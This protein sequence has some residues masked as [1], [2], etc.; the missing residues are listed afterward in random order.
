M[1]VVKEMC[2]RVGT[3]TG[4]GLSAVIKQ[5]YPKWVLWSSILLLIGANVINIYADLN[6]M[7]ACAQML[8]HGSFVIWLTLLTAA[9]TTLQ[10]VVPYRRYV[11]VLKW[12][13]LG[14]LAYVVTAFI[15]GVHN[16]WRAIA[17]HT[18]V[19]S[20]NQSPQ[21]FLIV[22]GFL[23]T[24][25]SPYLFFWQAGEEVEEQIEAGESDRPG[26]RLVPATD[27]ELRSLRID[28][29]AGM[30]ASQ[31]VTF[32]IIVCTATNLHEKGITD[33]NTAQDAARALLPLGAAAYWLF[34]LGILGTGALAIPTLAG[35]IAYS[36]CEA[37]DWRYGLYRRF[38][39]ARGF[40]LIIFASI[41]A[42]Y[43]LNFVRSISPIKGLLYSA[44]LNGIVAPPLIVLL[45]LACN[46]R[47]IF[48]ERVN[49]PISNVL[50]WMTAVLMGV[51]SAMLFWAM[52]TGKA[53]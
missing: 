52:A 34:A 24:T 9:I 49:K 22:I 42:G 10:I 20:W 37:N 44:A 4:Q 14:L 35:S 26:R 45:V 47:R 48:G 43:A 38:Q 31:S 28:T 12:F 6:A 1:I 40:Y 53:A 50:G 2:G 18:F 32:F 51:A 11:R 15:P 21:F 33:I 27:T 23:G 41:F 7:S 16:D 13:C 3:V 5:L 29:T 46:N 17:V 8:F 39:R 30:M 36:L 25:I 19:P